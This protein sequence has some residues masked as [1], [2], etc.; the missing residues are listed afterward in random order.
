MAR[1]SNRSNPPSSIA[2]RVALSP[3]PQRYRPAVPRQ[4]L[5]PI[6]LTS[7]Q[8]LIASLEDRRLFHPD[9]LPRKDMRPPIALPRQA[10]RVV[11]RRPLTRSG[12]AN[13]SRQRSFRLTFQ[14]PERVAMCAKRS[15][16]RQVLFAHRKTTRGPGRSPRR[17]FWSA[18]SCRRK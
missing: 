16:R 17:N 7:P 1:R 3:T 14:V 4:S 15:I 5:K 2:G 10:A 12:A 18:V 6:R 8:V 13:Q 9:S 11:A